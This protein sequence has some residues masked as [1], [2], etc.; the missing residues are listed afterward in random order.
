MKKLI[1]TLLVIV[2]ACIMAM[3]QTV[4]AATKPKKPKL[5]SVTALSSTSIKIKWK[6][7]SGASGYVIYQKKSSGS[8]KKIKTVTSGKTTSYT[9]KKLSNKTKYSYKI[10][11]YKKSGSEK[12]YS[13][14][15]NV[16]SV[17]TKCSHKYKSATCSSPKKCKYCGKKSGVALGHNYLAAT[18]KAPKICSVCKATKGE[19]GNHKYAKGKCIYC[20]KK[21]MI[22]PKTGLKTNG[23]YYQLTDNGDGNYTLIIYQFNDSFLNV[24]GVYSTYKEWE[25]IGEGEPITYKGKTYYPGG[26]GGP[27]PEYTITD[28]EIIVKYSE[29]DPDLATVEYRLIVNSEYDLEVTYS[30]DGGMFRKG[31]VLDLVE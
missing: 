19:I 28:T 4:L 24:S 14:Y 26:F 20:D 18:C 30:T 16:K 15:S 17:Y 11:A 13:K 21:Q 7:V 10:R 31:E 27:L 12:I 23:N 2:I 9:K 25:G 5:I 3:P 1:S 8:Y 29:D 6:K 22:N